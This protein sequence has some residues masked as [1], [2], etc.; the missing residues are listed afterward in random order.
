MLE[1][2]VLNMK[3][4]EKQG[5]TQEE[6]RGLETLHLFKDKLFEWA[7]DSVQTG[8]G[9]SNVS[10]KGLVLALEQ[11]EFSMQRLWKFEESKAFHTWWYE[12]PGCTCPK[13]DNRDRFGVE[14]RVYS[15]YCPFH[16]AGDE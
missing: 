1:S 15:H 5:L 14:E 13:L 12:L 3:L 6:V 10:Q 2:T 16:G 7:Y 9:L 11:L 4:A 8:N